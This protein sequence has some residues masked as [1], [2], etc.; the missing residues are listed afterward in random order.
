MAKLFGMFQ[1]TRPCGSRLLIHL[2]IND[3]RAVST[4]A[5]LRV[6]TP[7]DRQPDCGRR[8]FNSRDPAGRDRGRAPNRR[9]ADRFN[10]RDPA[11]RDRLP[12]NFKMG[13]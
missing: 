8:G 9:R 2:R 4:H 6:A 13:F 10:S 7:A 1:L 3:P 5:T 11:G 12:I